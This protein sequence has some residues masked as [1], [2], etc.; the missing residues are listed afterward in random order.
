M[1]RALVFFL[2]ALL[3]IAVLG[4]LFAQVV[5]IPT[6]AADEVELFPPYESVRLPF[7]VSA[8][9]FIACLQ[10]LAVALGGMLQRAGDGTV[11][12]SGALA[13][14]NIA[15]GAIAGG[16]LVLAWLFV[17]ITFADIP[18]PA[19]GMETLGLW[20]GS[21]VGTVAA[22]GVALLVVVGRHWLRRA[23]MQRA[24]LDQVV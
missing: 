6:T 8:I 9:V 23:I 1:T 13:W 10:V 24:E 17:F 7:V 18:S 21:A 11:F 16:G 2:Q 4:G 15:I 22:V 14:T 12:E 20:M 19:D 5:V 3:A